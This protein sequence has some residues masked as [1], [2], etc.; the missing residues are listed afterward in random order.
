MKKDLVEIGYVSG[1]FGVV[2]EVKVYLHN[3]D[4]EMFHDRLDCIRQ[5]NG[6]PVRTVS[7]VVRKGAGKKVLGRF[8]D[9][10]SRELAEVTVGS[11][12]FVER[13]ALPKL[14]EDEYYIRDLEGANV[15][16]GEE[17]F[18]CVRY[19]HSTPRGDI[20]EFGQDDSEVFFVPLENAY[21]ANVDLGRQAIELTDSG[22]ALL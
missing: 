12:L 3:P 11:R 15:M 10:T 16:F 6:Q 7:L 4:S 8:D 1:V 19:I 20:L 21:V 9:V 18:G 22:R 2:G 5:Q 14:P 13:R 17:S